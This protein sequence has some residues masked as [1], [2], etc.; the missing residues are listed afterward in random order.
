MTTTTAPSSVSTFQR[1]P[2]PVALR[3]VFGAVFYGILRPA[4]SV[5]NR[6]GLAD[7]MI[8]QAH[9]RQRNGAIK[10]PPFGAYVPNEHDVIVATYAKSGTNW[11]MQIAHQ[12]A[13]HGKA[14]FDHIHNFVPWPDSPQPMGKYAIPVGDPTV[15]MA[16]PEQKRVIKTHLD[17][18]LIPYSASARYIIV[19]RD[20]KDVFVSNFHFMKSV[21]GVGF[22]RDLWY[23]L[24]VNGKSP[25][26]GSWV[27][28][29]ALYWEQ[30][31]KPNV[32]V[33]SFKSMKQDLP[34]TVRKVADFMNVR[35]PDS[36]IQE[37]SEKA[38]FG[39]MK[40]IDHKFG[41]WKMF[42]WGPEP[43]MIRKGG[44]GG[45]SELLSR[46]E[47]REM[48]TKFMAELKQRNSDFPY[49]EFCDVVS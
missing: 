9:V 29:T 37:V 30:R 35:V 47:Q 22:P 20:P 6:L 31:R 23:R 4:V 25:V 39:Y 42:P 49:Q 40:K 15:W 24:F 48:D 12:L 26:G 17:W 21:T 28:N 33:L 18:D 19:I 10:R 27:A 43:T 1:K 5:M 41:V 32:L 44:Q 38:S 11:M 3:C 45:S 7:R 2:I 14:E 8:G 16:S 46:D 13:F 36:V 34:G